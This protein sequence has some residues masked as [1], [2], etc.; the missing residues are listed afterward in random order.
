[1]T[2]A[3]VPTLTGEGGKEMPQRLKDWSQEKPPKLEKPAI[4]KK[5]GKLPQVLPVEA[6]WQEW[7]PENPLPHNGYCTQL[8]LPPGSYIVNASASIR[9]AAEASG[10]SEVECSLFVG[11]ENRSLNQFTLAVG[12]GESIAAT[13]HVESAEPVEVQWNAGGTTAPFR[14]QLAV[15]AIEVHRLHHVRSSFET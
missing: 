3:A 15:T 10:P 11:Q 13:S 14:L 7:T 8:F 2:A 6:Y 1:M 4:A 5:L 9:L 12:E